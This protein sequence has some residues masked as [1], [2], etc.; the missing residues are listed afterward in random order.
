MPFNEKGIANAVF[1]S[2]PNRDDKYVYVDINGFIAAIDKSDP[3]LIREKRN[4]LGTLNIEY[5][6]ACIVKCK[7]VDFKKRL[8]YV[9]Y[10]IDE[11]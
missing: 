7:N 6:A 9:S 11:S 10:V 4:S 3:N 2:R 5:G 1:V 8:I